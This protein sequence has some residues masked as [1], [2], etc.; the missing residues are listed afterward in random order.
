M[1]IFTRPHDRYLGLLLLSS[2]EPSPPC[3]LTMMS[4]WCCD[5][6]ALSVCLAASTWPPLP[7]CLHSRCNFI[8]IEP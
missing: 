1:L 4:G 5:S 8:Y 2:N 3:T 7:G 6:T